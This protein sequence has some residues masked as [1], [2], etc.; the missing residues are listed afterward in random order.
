MNF[1]QTVEMATALR[2]QGVCFEQLIIH[3]EIHGFLRHASWLR[4]YTAAVTC[5]P[6]DRVPPRVPSAD[7]CNCFG[8]F[9][10]TTPPALLP[11]PLTGVPEKAQLTAQSYFS[12]LA[13]FAIRR[14]CRSA[15]ENFAFT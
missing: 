11:R 1:A 10:P 4:A 6:I 7:A 2:R 15:P 13:T 9:L 14:L 8:P 12:K 3:D 5:P